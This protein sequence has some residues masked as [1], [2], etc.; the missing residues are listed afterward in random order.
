L[1]RKEESEDPK[2]EK[3]VSSPTNG[4]SIQGLDPVQALDFSQKGKKKIKF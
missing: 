1:I 4:E 3:G 2:I